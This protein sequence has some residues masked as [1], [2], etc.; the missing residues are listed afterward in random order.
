MLSELRPMIQ[1][2][3][4]NAPG[5][6]AAI[7]ARC[8]GRARCPS[9]PTSPF[10]SW[11]RGSEP[12]CQAATSIVAST[13]AASAVTVRVSA[14]R[15]STQRATQAAVAASL[16]VVGRG[17]RQHPVAQVHEGE[18]QREEPERPQARDPT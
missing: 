14:N 1:S 6:S 11:H 10:W 4:T 9:Q 8:S 17:D 3:K 7:A 15:R 2:T 5:T 16:G 18:R 13:T 12:H